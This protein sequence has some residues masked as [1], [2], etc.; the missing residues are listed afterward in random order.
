MILH[1]DKR[2]TVNYV[3]HGTG[4]AIVRPFDQPATWYW[5]S[6]D[7]LQQVKSSPDQLP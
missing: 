2:V 6:V 5:A 1:K 3:D 7:E 4:K